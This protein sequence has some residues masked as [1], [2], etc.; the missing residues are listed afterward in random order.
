ML[1]NGRL[2]GASADHTG[3]SR[4]GIGQEHVVENGE[5]RR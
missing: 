1:L 5:I 3:P 2:G 4:R